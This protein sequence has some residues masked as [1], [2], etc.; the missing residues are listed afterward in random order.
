[1]LAQDGLDTVKARRDGLRRQ[2]TKVG[3]E[4]ITKS[5]GADRRA[6]GRKKKAST[7]NNMASFSEVYQ[8]YLMPGEVPRG[9]T[10]V[11]PVVP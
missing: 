6:G 9:G 11:N 8:R 2:V 3:G 1:M 4:I 5:K 10:T 7:A